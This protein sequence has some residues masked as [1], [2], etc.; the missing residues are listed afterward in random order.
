MAE[1]QDKILE[2]LAALRTRYGAELPAKIA[3]IRAR[4]DALRSLWDAEGLRTLHR[5]THSLTGSGAT[6]GYA[7]VSQAARKMEQSLK[8]CIDSGNQAAP[9]DW[10]A[11]ERQLVEL[12]GASRTAAPASTPVPAP[13]LRPAVLTEQRLL[14]VVDDDTDLARE[15][16]LQYELHGYTVREF[17]GFDGLEQAIRT[18][19]PLA[20]IMD[21]MFPEGDLAG[22][23]HIARLRAALGA[24]PPV[25]FAS[26]RE[27]IQARLESVRAGAAAYFIKPLDLA[28]VLETIDRLTAPRDPAPFR[29]L[30]LDD[31][32]SL[33]YHNALLLQRAGMETR[34]LTDPA[35]ILDVMGD[36][37]PELVLMDLYLP[38]CTGIELAAV[39]RQDAAYVGTPIIFLSVETDIAKH[40]E[41]MR[42]GGDD[43]LLKPIEA[44]HLLA[45]VE[46][47]VRRARTIT[48]VMIR[49]SLTGLLNHT[50]IEEQLVR[51]LS[52]QQRHASVLSYAMIDLDHF[53]QVNDR[54]GHA[55]GDRVLRTLSRLLRQRLRQT[56]LIGRYG[57]E[58]FVVVLPGTDAP[59][60]ARML[61]E[62]RQAFSA[63]RFS[64]G[65]KEFSATFS[66]GIA[67]APPHVD[68]ITIQN[69]ADQA[70]Y[71]AKK[72]GR[73]QVLIAD[74]E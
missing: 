60:A 47:R 74:Q 67:S 39:I 61:N 45:S 25:I 4:F 24:L 40:L 23:H 46:A 43:F 37:Q 1:T 18:Q 6:F 10:P 3:H 26:Q 16:R 19:S 49:D 42:A 2:Q 70:L 36:F 21:I 48:S 66:A 72:A 17:H 52:L 22:I 44:A 32:E 13:M 53:K 50:A 15:Q 51:E 28:A 31:D 62:L 5:L 55:M 41:A 71:R 34:V 11:W 57:G 35:G 63:I 7:A 12:E 27:D 29:I 64:A 58:E 8:T 30:I 56:D 20:I 68:A 14:F 69:K 73:N 33:A 9:E 38:G 59:T 54:Y 65:G